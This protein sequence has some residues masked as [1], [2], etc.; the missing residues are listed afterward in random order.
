MS[1]ARPGRVTRTQGR[2]QP[3]DPAI[4]PEAPRHEALR[5]L[6]A[7]PFSLGFFATAGAL[8][9]YWL[10]GLILS[11]SSLLVLIVVSLFLAAG[12]N[13]VVEWLGR[14]GLSRPWAVLAVITG[15]IIAI[16]LFFTALVPVIEAVAR[17]IRSWVL[18]V[19]EPAGVSN[20]IDDSAL[21][22]SALGLSART[23]CIPDAVSTAMSA[24][25]FRP[26]LSIQYSV[27]PSVV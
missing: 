23:V 7:H 9:A 4:V 19:S 14:R 2:R 18:L 21:P 10:G 3:R 6:I 27:L 5:T 20:A 25:V 8:L 24:A 22:M 1:P 13:P 12:L 16:A 15:V 11:V 26:R 17:T